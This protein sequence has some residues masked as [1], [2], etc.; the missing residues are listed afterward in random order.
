MLAQSLRVV[1]ATRQSFAGPGAPD[2]AA[3][4]RAARKLPERSRAM[5]RPVMSGSIWTTH[6]AWR[7][8]SVD[9]P[10]CP[11]CA[12]DKAD[13]RHLFWQCP[14]YEHHRLQVRILALDPEALPK[15]LALHGVAP[16]V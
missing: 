3:T 9:T 5:L 2:V 4:L 10:V 12:A 16:E 11:R 13:V 6:E 14:S 1:Q 15:F 7:A 8:G